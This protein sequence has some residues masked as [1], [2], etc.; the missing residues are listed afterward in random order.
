M[1]PKESSVIY[2]TSQQ[3]APPL[4]APLFNNLSDNLC[5]H[6]RADIKSLRALKNIKPHEWTHNDIHYD[7]LQM[8]TA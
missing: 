3:Q 1:T 6:S 7:V 5:G 2:A 4:T 8:S